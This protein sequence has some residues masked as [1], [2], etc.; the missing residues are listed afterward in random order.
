MPYLDIFIDALSS[1]STLYYDT[2]LLDLETERFTCEMGDESIIKSKR[3]IE[4]CSPH[5]EYCARSSVIQMVVKTDQRYR[6]LNMSLFFR[7]YIAHEFI[8]I[9]PKHIKTP[10]TAS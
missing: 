5:L 6:R 9:V 3:S 4:A 10:D 2:G 8:V 7:L 1:S